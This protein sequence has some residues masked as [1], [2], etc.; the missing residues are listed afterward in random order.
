MSVSVA[1]FQLLVADAT[2]S[3]LVGGLWVACGWVVGGW[4][5]WM[6][7]GW[8]VAALVRRGCVRCYADQVTLQP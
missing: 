8:W 3:R 6:L 4:C 5:C 1:L 7:G 2:G